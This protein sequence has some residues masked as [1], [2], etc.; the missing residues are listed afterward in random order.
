MADATPRTPPVINLNQAMY[1]SRAA[2]CSGLAVLD[3]NM[4]IIQHQRLLEYYLPHVRIILYD[5]CI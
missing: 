2:A 3:Y 1:R 4:N 5:T